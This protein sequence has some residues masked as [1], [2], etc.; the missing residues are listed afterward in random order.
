MKKENSELLKLWNDARVRLHAAEEA[1]Q[2]ERGVDLTH[3]DDSNTYLTDRSTTEGA[4]HGAVDHRSD[5]AGDLGT[6]GDGFIE[7]DKARIEGIPTIAGREAVG[8]INTKG[9]AVI[10]GDSLHSS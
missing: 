2:R 3:L 6:G 1:I 7:R 9:K 5:E 4:L 10:G 8:P